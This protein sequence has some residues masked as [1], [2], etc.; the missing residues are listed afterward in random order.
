MPMRGTDGFDRA[1]TLEKYLAPIEEWV[2]NRGKSS[3]H[4]S[5][6][7]VGKINYL[8]GKPDDTKLFL[9]M[10]LV[11]ILRSQQIAAIQR[12]EKRAKK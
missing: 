1:D 12:A 4:K 3:E 5:N 8:L 6:K 9:A 2:I 7:L 11:S 10:F